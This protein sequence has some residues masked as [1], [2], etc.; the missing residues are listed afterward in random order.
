MIF[1]IDGDSCPKLVRDLIIRTAAR[2]GS[3][4]KVVAN[5]PLKLDPPGEMV[6][7]GQ[8]EGAA[9]AYILQESQP[10]DLV[11]TRDIPLA[12]RLVDRGILA[13]N[14]R[15]DIFTQ[16]FVRER[17][18]VR[19]FSLD[20]RLAGVYHPGKSH[21]GQKEYLAFARTWDKVLQKMTK[22]GS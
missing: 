18:S 13:L 20:L 7:V 19:D 22:S 10:G 3:A 1:W 11:V 4:L 9:D 16:D 17:L 6:L 8:E 14:D 12:A 15:G 5:R 21:Y 2:L